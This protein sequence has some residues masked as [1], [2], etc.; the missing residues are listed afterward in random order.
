MNVLRLRLIHTPTPQ[1]EAVRS[2]YRDVLG[3]PETGGWEFPGDRG[4]FLEAGA[5]EIEVMEQDAAQLGVLPPGASGWC[6]S[7]EVADVDAEWLRLQAQGV[8]I[9][10]EPVTQPWGARDF[11][12]RDPAGNPVLIYQPPAG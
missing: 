1:W 11:V 9:L 2:F 7:L 12:V 8:P 3:L 6:L 4:A 5:A 10:R